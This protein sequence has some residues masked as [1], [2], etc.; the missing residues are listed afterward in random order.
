MARLRIDDDLG[1]EFVH[2]PADAR[3]APLW[4]LAGHGALGTFLLL[5]G[6]IEETMGALQPLAEAIGAL[7]RARL[8]H[9]LLKRPGEPE[10]ADELRRNVALLE[11]SQLFLLPLEARKEPLERL[12]GAFSRIVP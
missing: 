10:F 8:L 6:P 11:D 3:F 1:I 7:P 12:R 9:L 2:V 5:G 4:P